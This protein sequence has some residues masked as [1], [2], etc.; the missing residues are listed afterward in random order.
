MNKFLEKY[1][2]S[3]LNQGKVESR[4][5]SVTNTETETVI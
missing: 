3:K 5:K 1:N 4:N 2:L